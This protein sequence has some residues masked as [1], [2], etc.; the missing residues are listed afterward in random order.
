MSNLD[1]PN[2]INTLS[3]GSPD[4]GRSGE[5]GRYADETLADY[6]ARTGRSPVREISIFAGVKKPKRSKPTFTFPSVPPLF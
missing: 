1:K 6:L 3:E 2:E 5:D 4:L